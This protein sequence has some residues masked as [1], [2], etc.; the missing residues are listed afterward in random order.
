[1]KKIHSIIA[2][3]FVV[4]F[5]LI[6]ILYYVGTINQDFF[7]ASIY[8]GILNLINAILALVFFEK[9]KKKSNTLFLMFTMGGMGARMFFMLI[10]ILL[11]ILF[12][13]IDKYGFILVFFVFYFF[14]LFTEIWYFYKES[15]KFVKEK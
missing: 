5:L 2:S 13:N 9:A 12:L 7:I 15:R 10:V 4:G 11:L 6:A 1:M 8:A 14:L 3:I